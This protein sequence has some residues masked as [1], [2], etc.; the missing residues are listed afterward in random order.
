[1]DGAINIGTDRAVPSVKTPMTSE[2]LPRK[3][4]EIIVLQKEISETLIKEATVLLKL[5]I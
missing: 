1:L 3:S 4:S 5:K 2:W